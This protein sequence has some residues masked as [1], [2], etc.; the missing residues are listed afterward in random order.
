MYQNQERSLAYQLT[1]G[2]KGPSE[3][4]PNELL[5]VG[6]AYRNEWDGGGTTTGDGRNPN[7]NDTDF[8]LDSVFLFQQDSSL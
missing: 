4:S 1:I 6:G 3:M 8:T 5:L 2:Q 7:G